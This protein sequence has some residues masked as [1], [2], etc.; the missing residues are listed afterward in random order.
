[1]STIL[2]MWTFASC[3]KMTMSVRRLRNSGLKARSVSSMM[4]SLSFFVVAG[5]IHAHVEADRGLLRCSTS[6]P[7]F[8]VRMMIVFRKSTDA[9]EQSVRRPSSRTC[10]RTLMTSGWAFSISSKSTTE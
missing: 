3:W 6:A 1:M 2:V 9:A 7:T 5:G 10:S 4:R 8:E